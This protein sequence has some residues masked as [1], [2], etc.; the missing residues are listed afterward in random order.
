LVAKAGVVGVFHDG[1]ELHGIVALLLD[2]RQNVVLEVSV[3]GNL[4]L[5]R[6]DAHMGLVDAHVSRLSRAGVF[7]LI[8]LFNNK[9]S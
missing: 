5:G 2:K 6:R 3:G 8:S 1:H 9:N 7:E 4:G